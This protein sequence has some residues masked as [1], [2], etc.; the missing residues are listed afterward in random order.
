[1]G[2][3]NPSASSFHFN[4]QAAPQSHTGFSQPSQGLQD[5][6]LSFQGQA[7]NSTLNYSARTFLQSD[8]L[9]HLPSSLG[10]PTLDQHL[11]L[12]QQQHLQASASTELPRAPQHSTMDGTFYSRVGLATLPTTGPLPY[13]SL[14]ATSEPSMAMD[15]ATKA[16]VISNVPLKLQQRIIQGE[17]IDLSDLLQADF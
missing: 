3:V 11:A 4:S 6:T 12:N 14:T 15:I 2:E 8:F 7:H 1:M 13:S 10:T 5:Q 17:F 16:T 9:A